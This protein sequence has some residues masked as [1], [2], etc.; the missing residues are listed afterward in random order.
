[1]QINCSVRVPL[2]LDETF[3]KDPSN[4]PR[5]KESKS[6]MQM[7]CSVRVPLILDETFVMDPSNYPRRQESKSA[8]LECTVVPIR[9]QHSR[10]GGSLCHCVTPLGKQYSGFS[11]AQAR[12]KM[13]T[14]C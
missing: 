1:M 3:V 7:N 14:E 9:A 12:L 11:F 5:K 10:C 8:N 13:H 6:K 2:I 4:Y